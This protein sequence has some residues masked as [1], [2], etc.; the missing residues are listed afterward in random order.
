[1]RASL[2]QVLHDAARLRLVTTM[3][4]VHGAQHVEVQQ[5]LPFV[6]PGLHLAVDHARILAFPVHVVYLR[7]VAR[8]L[9]KTIQ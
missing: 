4:W 5:A 2:S 1:M 6:F 3:P 8:L 9:G 7:H